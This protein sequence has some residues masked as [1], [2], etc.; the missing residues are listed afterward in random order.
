VLPERADIPLVLVLVGE[1]SLPP[2]RFIRWLNALRNER[3]WEGQLVV[4][5][6]SRAQH[7]NLAKL[8]IGNAKSASCL[9]GVPGHTLLPPPHR[10]ADLL[11]STSGLGIAAEVWEAHCN[12]PGTLASLLARVRRLQTRAASARWSTRDE[13]RGRALVEQFQS[14]SVDLYSL[15]PSHV[16]HRAIES[17]LDAVPRPAVVGQVWSDY[18]ERLA[19]ALERS[20]WAQHSSRPRLARKLL[21]SG[22]KP[23]RG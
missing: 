3:A 7:Q 22:S 4:I 6:A 18:L 17:L 13:A 8:R 19:S 14:E 1:Q 12:C 15:L 11:H 20:P 21:T 2:V 5:C 10:L 23:E 16:E 9:A